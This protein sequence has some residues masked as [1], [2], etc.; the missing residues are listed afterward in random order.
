MTALVAGVEKWMG[1]A[2]PGGEAV[3]QTLNFGL[4]FVV[5]SALFGTLQTSARGKNRVARCVDRSSRDR[6]SV[7]HRQARL[8]NYL[9][10]RSVGSSFGAAGSLIV[11]LVWVYYS[12][13][14][15]FFGAELPQVYANR[16]G[17]HVSLLA[18]MVRSNHHPK[19]T[20]R[21]TWDRGTS[22][23]S[24]QQARA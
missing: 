8:G 2:L 13:Q 4:S 18:S 7:R 12:S 11:L 21:D 17:S 9:G 19:W 5:I 15:L 22:S 16:F 3:A 1:G 24:W 23:R 10:K 6:A 14:I 20:C